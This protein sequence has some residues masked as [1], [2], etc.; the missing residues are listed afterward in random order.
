MLEWLK[1]IL[2]E[3]Y[4]EDIDKK[5]SEEIGKNFVAKADFNNVNETKKTLEQQIKDRDKDIADLKKSAGDNADL[6]QK[7]SDLQEKYKKD[8]ES[9]NKTILDNQKNNAIEM[10][11][12]QAKGKNTK[13]IKALLDLD[14]ISLKDDG[15]I[16]G[17]SEQMENL[18]KS[19]DSKFLFEEVKK[20]QFKGAK[21][22]EGADIDDM[23]SITKEQFNKMGYKEKLN[24]FNEN[25]ELYDSLTN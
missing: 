8:T 4:S 15:T 7:Y 5:V 13:A 21:P 6:S 25:K 23:K 3:Q 9:L 1:E 20:N 10:A 14:K 12:M 11:I 22:G 24:L 16:E 17:L 2:G 19:D 18:T